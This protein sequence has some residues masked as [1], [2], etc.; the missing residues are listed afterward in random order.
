MSY[1]LGLVL[2]MTFVILFFTLGVDLITIQFAYSS[3]DAKST[4]IS[5]KISTHGMMD[6]SFITGLENQYHVD[7]E[8]KSNCTP[9]FGDIVDYVI[10]ANIQTL[11]VAN[12]NLT[13]RLARSAVIGFYA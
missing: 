7:I 4:A 6:D 10:S 1:K 13:I 11:I 8:C 9:Q 2:S 5:Y 3:L 12:N